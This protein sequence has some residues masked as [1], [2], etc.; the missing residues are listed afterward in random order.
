MSR[1]VTKVNGSSIP[2][3]EPE[4]KSPLEPEYGKHSNNIRTLEDGLIIEDLSAGNRDAEF[5]SDGKKVTPSFRCCVF[6]QFMNAIFVHLYLMYLANLFFAINK[7]IRKKNNMNN[8][9]R[10]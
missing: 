1:K 4:K 7:K 10:L 5:S 8:A 3:L 2:E 6:I 9:H